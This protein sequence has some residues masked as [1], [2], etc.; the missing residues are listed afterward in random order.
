VAGTAPADY[1]G[2]VPQD[3]AETITRLYAGLA[4]G[5]ATAMA[6]CYAE[7]ATFTDPFFRGLQGPEVRGMWDMLTRSASEMTVVADGIE[8]HGGTGRAHWVATYPFSRTGRTVVNDVRSEFRLRD[9]LIVEQRD[10]FDAGRWGAQ[11]FGPQGRLLA[12]PPA[13]AVLARSV[14]KRLAA[15]LERHPAPPAG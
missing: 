9:G 13:R 4:A 15:H 10:R 2:A 14:Q 12:L 3:D 5:D 1:G 6:R 11:A 8:A 7:D